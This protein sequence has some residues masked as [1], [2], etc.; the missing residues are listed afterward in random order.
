[1]MQIQWILNGGQCGVC[2]DMWNSTEP[3]DHELGGRYSTG[4]IVRRYKKSGTVNVI[5]ELTA[6]HG[7]Y[8]EFRLCPLDDQPEG[9]DASWDCLNRYLLN[10]RSKAVQSIVDKKYEVDDSHPMIHQMTV[11]LP[12]DVECSH[13]VF[14]WKYN[15]G[16]VTLHFNVF[17][18]S[19]VLLTQ[20]NM[21]LL[22]LF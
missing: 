19:F 22:H 1:M 3:R 21:P 11:E 6:S 4:T 10:V 2:G 7:G 13:C 20:I 5:I 14:Q 17:Y 18:M 12:A 8:F 16:E 9:R 15:T